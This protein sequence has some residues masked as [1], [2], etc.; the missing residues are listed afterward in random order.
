MP[1]LF[2]RVIFRVRQRRYSALILLLILKLKSKLWKISK[3]CPIM[4]SS[5]LEEWVETSQWVETSI[6]L[7]VDAREK[8]TGEME[9]KT[10]IICTFILG[11]Q[12]LVFKLWNI[13]IIY[14]ENFA[15]ENISG[16]W[17]RELVKKKR[18]ADPS[19]EFSTL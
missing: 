3:N 16:F 12:Q 17:L 7:N 14:W 2:W 19:V 1:V 4:T 18:G 13:M 11:K 15:V 5:V 6:N 8:F 10:K 9:T